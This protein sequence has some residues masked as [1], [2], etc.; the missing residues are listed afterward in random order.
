M[1][2]GNYSDLSLLKVH[3]I[4]K[5]KEKEKEIVPGITESGWK[6]ALKLGPT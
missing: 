5:K 4:K 2:R 1:L 3:K 6:R